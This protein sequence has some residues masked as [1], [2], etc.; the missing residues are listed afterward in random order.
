MA[1]SASRRELLDDL[2][3]AAA[4]RGEVLLELHALRGCWAVCW[5]IVPMRRSTITAGTS[6]DAF[7]TAASM[8]M[9]RKSS[10]TSASAASSSRRWTSA[11]LVEGVELAHADREIVVELRQLLLLHLL[12]GDRVVDRPA[13]QLVAAVGVAVGDQELGRLAR[14]HAAQAG[15]ELAH[16]APPPSSTR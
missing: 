12:D 4:G 2:L 1:F 14:R 5:R 3:E 16:Q 7:A 9:R 11:W 8:T 10:S 13:A 6:T 15:V